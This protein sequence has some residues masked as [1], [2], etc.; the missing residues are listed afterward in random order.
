[1]K[2][3]KTFEIKTFIKQHVATCSTLVFYI[4]I[5]ALNKLKYKL[6]QMIANV[7]EVYFS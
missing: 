2:K 3:K 5:H 1:M 7:P 6:E 4:K